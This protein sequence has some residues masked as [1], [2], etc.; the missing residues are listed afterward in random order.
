MNLRKVSRLD[1][2]PLSASYFTEEGYFRDRPI[3]TTCGIF[4]YI[5]DDGTVE[6]DLRLPEDVFD[7]ES[8]QSYLGKPII[9]THNAGEVTKENVRREQIGTILSAGI[10]DGEDV[11]AD[12]VIH[13]SERLRC[14]LRE[15]SLG[16]DSDLE[17]RPGVWNGE[18][19]DCIQHN[20]RINHLALVG[21]ARAGHSARLNLDGK[22]KKGGK[23]TMRKKNFDG[24]VESLTPEQLEAAVKLYLESNPDAASMATDEGED[25]DPVEKIRQ[26]ADRRDADISAVGTE[27]IQEM[28]EEIKTL[29]TEIDKVKGQQ[30]MTV[31]EDEHPEDKT[32]EGDNPECKQDED[33]DPEDKTDSDETTKTAEDTTVKMDSAERVFAEMYA[34]TQMASKL[35]LGGFAP[36]T[37]LDGKKTIIKAV[38]PKLK[39]DGKSPAYIA[40]AYEVACQQALMRKSSADQ[41]KKLMGNGTKRMDAAEKPNA[42]EAHERMVGRLL[43]KEGGKN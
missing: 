33:T 3:V 34:I 39:L 24:I 22:N 1:S 36:K 4:E 10:Q 20:I 21:E 17:E 15:L 25:V 26:N 19:Y 2:I 41:L 23:A 29:L 18:P 43:K 12:I 14:G 27:E 38:N 8:L 13:D 5:R 40:G 28:Q 11:R 16:Y 42:V 32:D 30:D 6:R 7:P 35:N 31:D 9:V 37:L